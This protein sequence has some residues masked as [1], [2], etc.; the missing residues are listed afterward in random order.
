MFLEL[1]SQNEFKKRYFEMLK[2]RLAYGSLELEGITG[3]LA[4]ARHS[5]KIFNQLDAINYMFENTD[6]NKPFS[7]FEFTNILCQVLQRVSGGEESDFRTTA[8]MVNGSK[9]ERT[10]PT[11]IRNDLW[12]LIDDYNYRMNLYKQ[13]KDYDEM[14]IFKLEAE[15]HIR[16][17]HI[18]PF[19]DGNGRTARI[20]LT[21]NLCRNNIAPCI[22][23]KETKKE[24]CD[25]IENG[26]IEGLAGLFKKLSDLEFSNMLALYSDLDKKGLIET[27]KMT[28]A[29][30]F[31]YNKISEKIR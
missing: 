29:Q 26:D 16:L 4:T 28:D 9:V 21:Y 27:N 31:E 18:H 1:D 22:I 17:L 6:C 12:Y 11:M 5:M 20:F 23:T 19:N 30:E 25:Y 24:Y 8:A 2:Y 10:K 15:F 3:N 14:D 7:H 13:K